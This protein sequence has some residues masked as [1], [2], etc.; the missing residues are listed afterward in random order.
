[1]GEGPFRVV[2]F[3]W[4]G[5]LVDSTDAIVAAICGAAA[6]LGLEVPTR[7]QASHVIGLG[8]REAIFTAVPS[9][10]ERQMDAY[11]ERYK[12]HF[13][14]RD[15]HLMPFDGIVGILDAL[16]D[17]DSWLAIATGK[18]RVGLDRAL[19]KT[20]WNGRFF[21]SRCADEGSPKP[22]PWMLEDICA[23]LGI[24]T[25]EA[26]MVGDTTHDL[27]MARRAG[28]AAIGVS[29]GAHPRA[30][31]GIEP[32]LAVVDTVAQLRAELMGRV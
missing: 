8:L 27:G 4:D 29:Y 16:A 6:D 13:F 17:S 32:A 20:G 9:I 7:E 30:E 14:Q 25:S 19:R 23:E 10:D 26:L 12:V 18:S 24:A 31:L 11:V 3:D 2:V 5:T 1:M 22:A 15:P 28:S 21:T